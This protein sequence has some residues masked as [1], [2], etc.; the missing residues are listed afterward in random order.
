MLQLPPGRAEASEISK[1]RVVPIGG[2]ETQGPAFFG[3][4]HLL[5]P[6]SEPTAFDAGAIFS[7]PGR[8]TMN[9]PTFM[10]M[11]LL[12]SAVVSTTA[13]QVSF[14]QSAP[15][16]GTWKLNLEKSK[17]SPGSAPRS[18]TRTTEA[19]GQSFRTTFEGISA[20]GNPTKVVF[21][22]YSYDGK[23]YP[24]TGTPNYD[25]ASYKQINNT[26][27]EITLI[28][29]GKNVQT[30]TGVFSSDGKTYTRLA[31]PLPVS[32]L[33]TLLFTRS[34]R[35]LETSALII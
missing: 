18:T 3:L 28:K 7:Y 6:T 8:N 15:Q 34:G 14:A 25:A 26:T 12:F 13:P 20:E 22:P 10:T 30:A 29:S 16:L 33:T 27:N 31:L 4:G 23:P 35:L 32:R 17:F 9:R 2:D 1:G 5:I 21:G 11:A 24:V 19:V